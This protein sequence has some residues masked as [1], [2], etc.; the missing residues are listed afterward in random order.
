VSTRDLR[1]G[2][3]PSSV[4]VQIVLLLAAAGL[5]GAYVLLRYGG[6]W[7]EGDTATFTRA[8]RS[9]IETGRLAGE[10]GWGVYGNGYAYPAILAFIVNLTGLTLAQIQI[11]LSP[12]LLVWPVVPAWLA[13][14]E[15]AGN[16]RA[17]TLATVILFTQPEF[18]F[19]VERGTHE[20]FTR[21]LML[22]L[23][24]LLLRSQRVRN[25][26]ARLMAFV[27]AFYLVGYALI[28]SNNL[29]AFSFAAALGTATVAI[30]GLGRLRPH[31]ATAKSQVRRMAIMTTGLGILSF[32]FLFY[33]YSPAIHGFLL[34]EEIAVQ[35][36]EVASGG[37]QG[38]DPYGAVGNLWAYPLT[39]LVLSLANWLLLGASALLWLRLSWRWIVR[40]DR[41][42]RNELLLWGLYAAFAFQGAL[43][44]VADLSGS[45]SSNLQH[46]LFPSFALLAAPLL[47]RYIEQ[48]RPQRPHIRRWGHAGL[49][50]GIGVVAV[51]STLKAT[52]EPLLSNKWLFYAPAEMRAVDWSRDAL[53]YR[54]VW[55]DQDER[56]F[57]AARM[58][59]GGAPLGFA[60]DDGIPDASTPNFLVTDVGIARSQR[61]GLPLPIAADDLITYDNGQAQ[62]YHRRPTTPYQP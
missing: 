53:P 7:G 37:A 2:P 52:N 19:V 33:V 14:R 21:G 29:M 22:L 50:V 60:E 17:A 1:R 54:G 36:G 5:L 45:L 4:R 25:A 41:P 15:L 57:S 61:L 20:K 11:F 23:L 16:A 56:L 35:V 34:L 43:S 39:Y 24:Y 10:P 28:T 27:A 47:A 46:R 49:A 12:L 42:Q 55:L 44:I 62:M 18:L 3:L 6:L 51:L 9:V 58:R 30:W 13:F 59:L 31:L 26:P 32:V 40:R 48:W 8:T 38:G